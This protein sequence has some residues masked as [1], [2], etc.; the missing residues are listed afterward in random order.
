[1]TLVGTWYITDDEQRCEFNSICRN[2]YGAEWR[3]VPVNRVDL[4]REEDG[5]GYFV[6][7]YYGS[8]WQ[9]LVLIATELIKAGYFVL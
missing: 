5:N 8:H 4:M 2:V 3:R 7:V 9:T 1:M 6:Y